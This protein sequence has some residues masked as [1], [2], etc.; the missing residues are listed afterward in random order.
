MGVFLSALPIR[1]SCV[2]VQSMCALGEREAV[3]DVPKYPPRRGSSWVREPMGFPESVM[4][5]SL[6]RSASSRPLLR[7]M[8]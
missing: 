5:A 3:R 7:K 1:V 8:N 4:C 2:F 6:A